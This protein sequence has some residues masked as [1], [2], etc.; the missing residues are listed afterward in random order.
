[1]IVRALPLVLVGCLVPCG[2]ALAAT[3]SK[4]KHP[5]PPAARGHIGIGS[6]WGPVVVTPPHPS[7]R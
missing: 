2:G 6:A 5:K 7:G 3:P 4:A 1:M